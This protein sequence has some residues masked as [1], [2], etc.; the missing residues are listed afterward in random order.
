MPRLTRD[1]INFFDRAYSAGVDN[2]GVIYALKGI[3]CE[4]AALRE[5]VQEIDSEDEATE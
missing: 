3:A 1:T 4:L 5:A 2:G